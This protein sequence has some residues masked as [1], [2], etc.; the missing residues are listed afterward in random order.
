[1]TCEKQKHHTQ[2]THHT[3]HKHHKH[4]THHTH[5]IH[6]DKGIIQTA[7]FTKKI[8]YFDYL[9]FD[10]NDPTPAIRKAIDI[11]YNIINL[12]FYL[13][14][15]PSFNSPGP[16]DI[17]QVWG[18]LSKEKQIETI[19]Y[20][21]NRGAKILVSAGGATDNNV[22]KQNPVTYAN[23]VCNWALNNNL[24]GVDYD[25]EQIELGFFIPGKNSDETYEWFKQLNITSRN[26]LGNNRII[27]HAPQAPYLSQPGHD[28]TWAGKLGGYVKVFDD[29][30]KN[31]GHIDFLN[32]QFYNQG[33]AYY[34]Y[35][36]IF[37]NGSPNFPFSAINQVASQGLNDQIAPVP[38][39]SIVYGTYLQNND[40]QGFHDPEEIKKI[41]KRAYDELH[42]NAGTMIWLWNTNGTPTAENWFNTV[43]K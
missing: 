8:I 38:I 6:C 37:E 26:I 14:T 25:M 4:H 9:G 43:Y 15:N 19:N 34:S 18:N 33:N 23:N 12:A 40:G 31:G 24:D 20:A 41:M 27:S 39:D 10:W 2:H 5:H 3:H 21:H 42:W 32:V 30:K 11:G 1:M 16:T 7:E 22:Y 13:S 29:A 36:T 35:E 17:A 28:N